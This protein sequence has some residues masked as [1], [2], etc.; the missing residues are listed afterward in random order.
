MGKLLN[1]CFVI[2]PFSAIFD[3]EYAHVI[4]PAIEVAGLSS[5]R[6]DQIYSKPQIMA[7]IWKALRSS[8][9][10]IAELSEKNANVFYEVGLAHALGKPVITITRN[11]QDVPFDLKALRYLYYDTNNP[12]WGESLKKDL[13]QMISSILKESEFGTV[14]EGIK[15]IITTEYM[16]DKTK[17]EPITSI[18]DLTGAWKG[19]MKR[20]HHTV[21]EIILQLKQDEEYDLEGTLMIYKDKGQTI[22]KESI[23]GALTKDKVTL[24]GVSYTY[25]RKGNSV[26][27]L[28]DSFEGKVRNNNA[29]SGASND[30]GEQKGMFWLKRLI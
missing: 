27:W 14:F 24:Y 15:P 30:I 25:I 23:K 16:E 5:V 12:S 2:M 11:E 26:N 7:D 17:T 18:Y 29:I 4:R 8:R 20:P 6:A 19:E 9:I 28:L 3:A 1:S 13:T 10:V 22:I 21:R